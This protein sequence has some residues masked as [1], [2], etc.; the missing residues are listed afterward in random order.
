MTCYS[1]PWNE[2]A[3]E[4]FEAFASD[5]NDVHHIAATKPAAVISHFKK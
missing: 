5:L 4:I 2:I 1:I 3:K